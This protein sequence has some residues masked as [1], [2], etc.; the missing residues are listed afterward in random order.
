MRILGGIFKGRNLPT[1]S[2]DGC[3]PAMAVVREALFNML[4]ARG[5]DLERARVLDIFAGTGS[6]GFEALSRGARFAHFVEANKSLAKRIT[7]NARA[8]GLASFS[9]SPANALAFLAKPPTEPFNLVFI[10][11]P[12]GQNLLH[13]TLTLLT[14]KYWLAPDALIAAEVEKSLSLNNPPAGL[15]LL[16]DRLYGQ[17]RI[18]LWNNLQ[19]A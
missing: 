13:P 7:E 8:L 19:N 11:P 17:T 3:R 18:L 16:T 4:A 10:D 1:L 12:Y 6:L 2:S 5:L 9:S 14:S 15:E